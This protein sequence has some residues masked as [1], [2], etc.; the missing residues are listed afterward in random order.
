MRHSLT[1]ILAPLFLVASY[2]AAQTDSTIDLSGTVFDASN[3]GMPGVVVSLLEAGIA[4]T[5][6]ANGAWHVSY[7]GSGPVSKRIETLPR[8][9]RWTGSEVLLSLSEPSRVHVDVFDL[10]GV[11]IGN[12]VSV[13]LGQGQHTLPVQA[14]VATR[15]ALIRVRVGSEQFVYHWNAPGHSTLAQQVNRR[16]SALARTPTPTERLILSLQGQIITEDQVPAYIAAG[17]DKWIEEHG[18]SGTV[19]PDSLVQVDSVFAWFDGGSMSQRRRAQM[20]FLLQGNNYQFSG[21][22]YTVKPTSG[23]TYSFRAWVRVMGT[24]NGV[25]NRPAGIS[26]TVP[27]TNVFGTVP[28]SAFRAGNMLPKAGPVRLGDGSHDTTLLVTDSLTVT[29]NPTDSFGGNVV[30]WQYAWL[31]TAFHLGTANQP[32]RLRAPSDTGRAIL[33]LRITDNDNNTVDRAYSW[34]IFNL[35]TQLTGWNVHDTLTVDS[36]WTLNVADRDG[37]GSVVVDWGDG[38]RDSVAHVAQVSHTYTTARATPYSAS[39]AVRDTLGSVTRFVDTVLVQRVL[40]LTGTLRNKKD[41]TPISGAVVGLVGYPQYDSIEDP[42]TAGYAL[43]S[44]TACLAGLPTLPI[45]AVTYNSDTIFIDTASSFTANLAIKLDKHSTSGRIVSGRLDSLTLQQIF[46]QYKDPADPRV[47]SLS[48]SWDPNLSNLYADP[49]YIASPATP[50]T[51]TGWAVALDASQ[52]VVGRSRDTTFL[53]G[54]TNVALKP[55]AAGNALPYANPV[56]TPDTATINDSV[57]VS[58]NVGDSLGSVSGGVLAWW[59]RWNNGA[60]MPGSGNAFRAKTPATPGNVPYVIRILDNDSNQVE[61]PFTLASVNDVP[62]VDIGL[63]TRTY[64]APGGSQVVIHASVRDHGSIVNTAWSVDGASFLPSGRDTSFTVPSASE[65]LV[66]SATDEDG[67]VGFDTVTLIAGFTDWRDGQAYRTVTIG[68][69]VW[70]KENL[71][72]SGDD[73]AG[74]RT[75]IKGWCYGVG[76]TDSSQHQ[77]STTCANG[78]GR[79]YTW[80]LAMNLPGSFMNTCALGIDTLTWNCR[81]P[82]SNTQGICP[83]GWHVSRMAEWD[84]LAAFVRRDLS[85]SAGNEAIYLKGTVPLPDDYSWNTMNNS[86]DPYGFSVL[87]AGYREYAGMI[88][89]VTVINSQARGN[90]TGFWVAD[91]DGNNSAHRITIGNGMT[92]FDTYNDYKYAGNQIRCIKD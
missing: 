87:P 33:T 11:R 52:R 40:Q 62:K 34:R 25:A 28:F 36:L 29:T 55:F 24:V 22:V 20:G 12:P 67:N 23:Q 89:S 41:N 31:D 4:D 48:M 61:M 58:V 71:N 88:G 1:R 49:A 8:D 32:I 68:N 39:M 42:L 65:V 6:D 47:W 17:L 60:W 15:P 54:A 82:T 66:M 2:A 14:D 63:W 85:I 64:G 37:I 56:T 69:Q 51:Y 18:I 83:A 79:Q 91:D 53:S 3:K 9:I 13:Q 70:M 7:T 5:T 38:H 30:S 76:G 90:Y 78:Y 57:T 72:Y 84:T 43:V 77:D 80:L 45:I 59:Y 92:R 50:R 75:Y 19:T 74:H 46:F 86:T 27:F 81:A 21:K 35:P 10:R 26:D 73:G 16:G 44:D